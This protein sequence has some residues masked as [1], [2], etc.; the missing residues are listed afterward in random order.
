M[1]LLDELKSRWSS[2]SPPPVDEYG[3]TVASWLLSNA[4]EEKATEGVIT[5]HLLSNSDLL[6]HCAWE[7]LPTLCA[8]QWMHES[9]VRNN[10]CQ[11]A[12]IFCIFLTP[13]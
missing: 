10:F 13:T 5:T 8:H 7:I 3:A 9:P 1:E 6:D 11:S 12:L 4:N 2:T